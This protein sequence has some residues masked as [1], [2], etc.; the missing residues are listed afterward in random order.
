LALN[1]F[2]FFILLFLGYRPIIDL[3]TRPDWEAVSAIGTFLA[4]LAALFITKWQDII[5]NRKKL[6]IEWRYAKQSK[7]MS[8]NITFS[9]VTEY[10][11]IDG[12]YIELTNIGNRK[13]IIDSVKI[14]F[15]STGSNVLFPNP[16]ITNM[17]QSSISYP[18]VLEPE[19]ASHL[20]L[21][22]PFFLEAVQTFLKDGHVK[23]SDYIIIEASDTTKREYIYNTKQKYALFQSIIASN[24]SKYNQSFI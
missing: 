11:Q 19:M 5:S 3:S 2:I 12:I 1:G 16:F 15:T 14:K 10:N 20:F 8:A 9:D 22:Y 21:P 17:P 7:T 23:V 6:K 4:V 18:C 24:N 13:I